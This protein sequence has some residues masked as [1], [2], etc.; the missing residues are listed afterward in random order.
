MVNKGVVK[1]DEIFW[2][3]LDQ[4]LGLNK[5]IT[6][7]ELSAFL[8]TN[9]MQIRTKTM[10]DITEDEGTNI[11]SE[12]ADDGT[13]TWSIWQNGEEIYGGFSSEEAARTH[14]REVLDLPDVPIKVEGTGAIA[15]PYRPANYKSQ[16]LT[17]YPYSNYRETIIV[18]PTPPAR[19]RTGAD[20]LKAGFKIGF[21]QTTLDQN[22]NP[23]T[24]FQILNS[25]GVKVWE[26][27]GYQFP[28]IP[29][30]EMMM[31]RY[32]LVVSAERGAV[33]EFRNS[34]HEEYKG[35]GQVVAHIRTTDRMINGKKYLFI[36]ELQ[37]D[38][39]QQGR[40]SKFLQPIDYVKKKAASNRVEAL[41]IKLRAMEYEAD[42]ISTYIADLYGLE[43]RG[44]GSRIL[45]QFKF[46]LFP[47]RFDQAKTLLDAQFQKKIDLES[48][49]SSSD[50][51][52]LTKYVRLHDHLAK[53]TEQ[54]NALLVGRPAGPWV[55][56]TDQ[57]VTLGLKQIIMQAV[58]EGYDGVAFINGRQSA[59]RNSAL[60]VADE[61]RYVVG[62]APGTY[63]VQFLMS[64][65][66]VISRDM[67]LKGIEDTLGKKVADRIAAGEGTQI[68]GMRSLPLTMQEVGGD[69]WF[70]YYDKI[71]P[72]N[73][74]KLLRKID[75]PEIKRVTLEG[76][77]SGVEQV[78][79]DITTAME[80][81]VRRGL[82]MFAR[83]RR[84]QEGLAFQMGRRSGQVAG[85][86]R[87][88]QQGI[89]EGKTRQ[90]A[91]ELAKR[92]E[93]RVKFAARVEKFEQRI[94]QDSEKIAGLRD[95]M[96][97]MREL[98]TD[99]RIRNR[100]KA[101]QDARR[102]VLKAWFAGQS[103]GSQEGFK[104]AKREMV[105]MR[106]D[107]LEIIK[108]LPKSMRANYLNA[109]TEMRTVDGIA[110]IAQR[111]VQDMATA[112]AIDVVNQIA[113]MTK[114]VR[115]AG[116]RNETRDDING[117]LDSARSLLV[118]GQKRLLPFTTTADLRNRTAAA[119]DLV[120]QAVAAYEAERQE[121]RDS[122][123]AR[124]EEFDQDAGDLAT[125]L[126]GQRGLP[127]ERLTSEAPKPGVV[128]RTFGGIANL[129]I[130]S[131]MHRLEGSET[132][133]L[134]KIWSGL[135]AGKDAMIKQRRSIDAK[136][137]AALRRAGYDGY[138]GYAARAAGL[139]GDATAETVEVRIA[140]E[141][142]RI[143]IDQM[144]HLAA[145]DDETVAGLRDESDPETPASP[146][147]F[148]T[149]RY[150]DPMYFTKQEHA[151]L[152]ASLS[153]EQ[154][155]LITSLKQLL[156]SDI[157][158]TLFE[159]H[160]QNVG[161]QPE[162]VVNYFPRQ[163]LGDEVA[164]EL[165]DVNLQPGQVVTSM[166]QNA[167][168]LQNR[169]ASR[170]PLVIGGMI[171]TLDGHIDESLR[172]IHLSAPLRHA[173]TVLRRR[174]VRS[175][176]ER[177]LGKGANDSIRKLVM[178]GAGMSG[179]PSND[180]VERINSNIS[181]ALITINP[182]T[183]LRQFG[184]AIRLMSEFPVQHWA[185][186][187]ARTFAMLPSDRS[188]Q[189][190]EIEDRNGYFYER[191]RRSQVGLFANVL[192]DPKIGREKWAAAIASVGRALTN[193]GQDMAAGQWMRA[194]NDVQQGAMS[195][196]K[197]I[198]SMDSVLRG[199]DRQIML[200]AYNAAL[201]QVEASGATGTALLDAA[202]KLA[203]RSFRH[204]QNVSDP[205]DDTVFAANQK[206]NR[207]LARFLF[208]F[209]SDPMKGYN[210]MRQA[211]SSGDV[212]QIATTSGA[213]AGNMVWSAAVNP[214]WT[215]IAFGIA[216]A[217]DP[218]EDDEAIVEMLKKREG[219]AILR[220]M[221]SDA[222]GASLGYA[223]LIA[224][225]VMEGVFGNPMYASDSGEPL[226]VR[227]FGDITVALASGKFGD[228][229]ATA[230]QMAGIPAITPVGQIATTVKA[231][232][233]DRKKLI[234]QY[235]L[236]KKEGRITPEQEARLLELV[237][238]ERLAKAEEEQPQ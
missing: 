108:M 10:V 58:N 33:P 69:Q 48:Q 157:Q 238:E 79:F 130:Y 126:S 4:W 114:R 221:A 225:G 162:R 140:G 172:V 36:E 12:V 129:D 229:S 26:S 121:F 206:F 149:Y 231:V 145:L 75:G 226:A 211:V 74:Q 109:I 183:W 34:H 91:I 57:W 3:G 31:D 70:A 153:P 212:S 142:R 166:L 62:D 177:I 71:V 67:D 156:E 216:S 111:V 185:T 77:P 174:G 89:R 179:R 222:A 39:A 123:D 46:A 105:E 146:I 128:R 53:R 81:K 83:A 209:S 176:I 100:E 21:T 15:A 40:K 112:D 99:M 66:V 131:L 197:I 47:G 29:T 110:R 73:A 143:T 124:A 9:G 188:R 82:T 60:A 35:K 63:G 52:I 168:M 138:D 137:D 18:I 230:L 56:S 195:I 88:R 76:A 119:I 61:V 51:Y 25:S 151:A 45:N 194:A 65:D 235:R 163:R 139:Y 154:R 233:P 189:I 220:R 217:F 28:T 196:G 41:D 132:G 24:Y 103:K 22:N 160:F 133:I 11:R 186:G 187:M 20:L 78:A 147:V 42:R 155:D 203:E 198:R 38:W 64:G 101:I 72:L 125:T 2:S 6:K 68:A 118:T 236:M 134:G 87:G 135:I 181:G 202:G 43:G 8:A 161:K 199:I 86:M 23:R 219:D 191:H 215:A 171:R 97:E 104:Q 178:N 141:M 167:G 93:M 90:Q 27:R 102:K 95:R 170:A 207:G 227:A 213:L 169:V 205:L 228:A 234:T 85:M 232:R 80:T 208:P 218:G 190:K 214:L 150:G 19:R 106:R 107:A 5:K 224:S 182:K 193:A 144:L 175:N 152:L 94:E 84:G 173:I 44:R 32:A 37:S 204:T 54:R 136:I 17:Q 159:I 127:P 92:R 120:E 55:E 201:S 16:T 117:L 164:G 158:P 96:R 116:L 200:V 192:G 98:A 223:G 1:A 122:R 49:L 50:K 210:Q 7:D 184:G 30:A 14:A 113:G 59:I 165:V 13:R 148:A 115:K 237:Q 180:I